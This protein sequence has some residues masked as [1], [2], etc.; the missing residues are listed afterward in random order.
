[1]N[2]RTE[3][4]RPPVLAPPVRVLPPPSSPASAQY[5]AAV[6]VFRNASGYFQTGCKIVFYPHTLHR[7][8]SCPPKHMNVS[9]NTSHLS[10]SR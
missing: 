4:D 9:R 1:M 3:A 7:P 2:K 6:S 5:F 8:T 10:R